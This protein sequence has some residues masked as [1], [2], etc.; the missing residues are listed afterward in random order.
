MVDY[1]EKYIEESANTKFL[2]LK[3]WKQLNWNN[4][5]DL[6]IPDLSTACYAVTPMFHISKNDTLKTIYFVYIHSIMK[7]GILFW[8]THLTVN[9]YLLYKRKF[10]ELWL[11]QDKELM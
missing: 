2:C 4:N 8:A 9:R 5:S 7:Q 3:N 10:F 11:V 1:N 6:I